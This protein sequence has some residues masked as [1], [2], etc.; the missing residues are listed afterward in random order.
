MEKLNL[1]YSFKNIP[2]PGNKSYQ[3]RLIEKIL[4]RIRSKAPF[5]LNF[6]TKLKSRIMS[7]QLMASN[8]DSTSNKTPDI[9]DFEKAF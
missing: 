4:K 7:K 6:Q 1:N 2:I 5:F 9:E 8:R 3:V